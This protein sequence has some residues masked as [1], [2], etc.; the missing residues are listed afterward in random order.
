MMGQKK[1]TT[2]HFLPKPFSYVPFFLRTLSTC[3]GTHLG[4]DALP[5]WLCPLQGVVP[6]TKGGWIGHPDPMDGGFP[7]SLPA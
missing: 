3:H 5:L 2:N 6:G 7:T 1:R 4:K